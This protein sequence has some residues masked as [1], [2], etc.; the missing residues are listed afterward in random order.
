MLLF[1]QPSL[2]IRDLDLIKQMTI[3]DFDH[4]MDHQ[5]FIP[6]ET[7]PLMGGNLFSMD[8]QKWR[9]MRAILSPAFTSSKM[10]GMFTFMSEC[11]KDFANYFLEQSNGKLIEVEMKDM[12]TR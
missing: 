12:F 5:D 10:R 8:G 3:K 1:N 6:V 9:E 7:D 2:V 4:F 11:A